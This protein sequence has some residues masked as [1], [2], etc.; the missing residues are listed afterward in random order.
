MFYNLD[1]S[2][3]I[4]LSLV[5]KNSGNLFN[6]N[7]V[8]SNCLKEMEANGIIKRIVYDDDS[9][10]IEYKLTDKGFA[11]NKVIFELAMFSLNTDINNE[12]YT[13]EEKVELAEV[14]KKQLLE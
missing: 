13:D 5:P 12:Y 10:N 4:G 11:L 1:S 9:L 8:L 3:G 2:I 6:L 7:K 14:F